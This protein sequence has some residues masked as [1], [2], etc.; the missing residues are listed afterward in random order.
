MDGNQKTG[1][2]IIRLEGVQ[3]EYPAPNGMVQALKGI[4]LS[5]HSGEFVG[6]FGKS[7]AG[8]TTLLNMMT[9]VD[10]LTRGTVWVNDVS[11]HAMDENQLAYWRGR[12]MGVIYQSFQLMPSLSLLANVALPIDLCGNYRYRESAARAMELLREV[13]LQD[14]AYKLPCDFRRA[15]A[16]GGYCPR[17]GQ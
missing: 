11:I 17:A 13:D 16:A 1:Q 4:D 14:H 3:K 10:H 15:A 9:G 8:K 5:I 12:N 2:P 7:G 6:I